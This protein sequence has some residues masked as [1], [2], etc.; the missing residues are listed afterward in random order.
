MIQLLSL[1]L[2]SDLW[3]PLVFDVLV[4]GRAGDGEADDEDVGLRVGQR[5]QPVVLLLTRRVPQVQ[6]DDPAVHRH[7]NAPQAGLFETFSPV[8]GGRWCP[9]AHLA[10]VVVEHGGDVLLR[11]GSGGV[12]DEEAGLPHSAVSHNHTLYGLHD[13]RQPTTRTGSPA[14][15]NTLT[16]SLKHQ[17][18]VSKV[19]QL[20]VVTM[21]KVQAV[22]V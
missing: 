19:K 21:E 13:A 16:L 14:G 7:L 22:H 10:A 11:K 8:G 9:K 5:P 18:G 17:K 12:G 3:M 15:R 20:F 6:T 1:I 4:G 2:T